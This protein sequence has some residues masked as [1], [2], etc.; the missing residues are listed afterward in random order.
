MLDEADGQPCD[1]HSG[2]PL[3]QAFTLADTSAMLFPGAPAAAA[4][5]L[6]CAAEVEAGR[7]ADPEIFD[8]CDK[9]RVVRL[10]LPPGRYRWVLHF[11]DHYGRQAR[12]AAPQRARRAARAAPV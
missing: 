1:A 3:S 7:E 9:W 10:R 12:P 6:E 8:H 11:L 4:P 5:A 2:C